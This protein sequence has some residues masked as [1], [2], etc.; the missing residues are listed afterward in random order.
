MSGIEA[1]LRELSQVATAFATWK[2]WKIIRGAGYN[3]GRIRIEP[4]V[5]RGLEYYT[6]PV[7][8]A[9]LT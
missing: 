7:F 9:E 8:E 6:G 2:I 5:V 4:S 1:N 3:D